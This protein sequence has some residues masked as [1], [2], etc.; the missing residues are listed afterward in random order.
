MY[1][2][3]N[4]TRQYNANIKGRIKTGKY[5]VIQQITLQL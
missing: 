3:Y 2:K 1:N 4:N 5:S